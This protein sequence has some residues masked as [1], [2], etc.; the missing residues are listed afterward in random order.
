L[1]VEVNG[2][3]MGKMSPTFTRSCAPALPKAIALS[4][5]DVS[6]LTRTL[7]T[8]GFPSVFDHSRETSIALVTIGSRRPRWRR[9]QDCNFR[10]QYGNRNG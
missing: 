2:P 7:R 5:S 8:I 3:V 9:R 4:I 1:P 10:E 6:V